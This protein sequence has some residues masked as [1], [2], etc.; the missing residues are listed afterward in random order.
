MADRRKQQARQIIGLSSEPRERVALACY[1]AVMNT[2]TCE[3]ERLRE[4][5][6][7]GDREGYRQ[8]ADL[9]LEVVNG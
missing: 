7:M 1:F 6:E 2:A 8:Q 4:L 9:I 5:W 3:P